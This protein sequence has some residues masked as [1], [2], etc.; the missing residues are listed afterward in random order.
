MGITDRDRSLLHYVYQFRALRSR[1]HILPLFEG[2]ET[3]LRR[4][5]HLHSE[6]YLYR[7]ERDNTYTQYLYG[8]GNKGAEELRDWKPGLSVPRNDWPHQHRRLKDAFIAHSLLIA[9][10]IVSIMVAARD[11]EGV[12]FISAQEIFDRSPADTRARYYGVQKSKKDDPYRIDAP[13]VWQDR[14]RQASI[15]SDWIFGLRFKQSGKNVYRYFFL[16]ADL[17]NEDVAPTKFEK[18]SILKKMK[19]YREAARK[20]GQPSTTE[21]LYH[22]EALRTLFVTVPRLTEGKKRVQTFVQASKGET[23]GKG[24][25]QFLFGSSDFLQSSNALDAPLIDGT[26]QLVTLS[27]L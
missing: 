13:I 25:K 19:V 9:D 10:V 23:G 5:Q 22:I 16:E 12:D 20:N 3:I 18:A 1:D 27:T 15:Y 26:G 17:D 2:K 7:F 6:G 24:T 8:L 4:A 11:T 14:I 21:R